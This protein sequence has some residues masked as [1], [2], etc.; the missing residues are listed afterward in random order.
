MLERG[1]ENDVLPMSRALGLSVA[2]FNLLGGGRLTGKFNQ[3]VGPSE[4]TRASGADAAELAAADVLLRL[5]GELDRS[6]SQIAVQWVRRRAPHVIPILG[7]R[8][9]AQLADTLAALDFTLSDE[10]LAEL[11]AIH[12]PAREY[13]HSFWNDTIPRDLI[14]GRRMAEIDLDPLPILSGRLADSV[15]T[16]EESLRRI[17]P[18]LTDPV[19]GPAR[20]RLFG[21]AVAL[22][23]I[24]AIPLLWS[25]RGAPATGW[26]NIYHMAD[27][28][29][30]DQVVN[31]V[32]TLRAP[33][34]ILISLAEIL[35]Y[36]LAGQLFVTT[37]VAYAGAIFFA[38]VPAL[39]LASRVRWRLAAAL[40][41]S[42]IFVWGLLLVH[43][44]NPVTYDVIFACLV[45]VYIVA[46]EQAMA[47]SLIHI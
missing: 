28:A 22:F 42:I 15:T 45:M 38:F 25:A 13:P 20:R 8:R 44:G 16:G 10:H 7:A 32:T 11:N 24:I 31:F 34:P 36:G 19:T 17:R 2:A 39:W 1:I 40:I 21:A 29:T 3:P 18:A 5:A 30:W 26:M 12:P 14:Y 27:F 9:P 43:A 46:L 6:P 47:L 41:L 23:S 37:R 33:I 4:P 35:E